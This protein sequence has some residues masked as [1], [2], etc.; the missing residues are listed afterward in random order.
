MKHLIPIIQ[1][2]L[3][4]VIT[5]GFLIKNQNNFRSNPKN[6]IMSLSGKANFL[7]EKAPDLYFNQCFMITTIIYVSVNVYLTLILYFIGL[8]LSVDGCKNGLKNEVKLLE[9]E[10]PAL[11][12][13]DISVTQTLNTNRK[14]IREFVKSF[15]SYGP[16]LWIVFP[17]QSE[18]R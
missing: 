10:F 11:L 7:N 8:R 15:T 13:N 16:D 18:C 1:F 9:V 12:K 14:F 5:Y 3:V 4:N 6:L 2:I 17:D